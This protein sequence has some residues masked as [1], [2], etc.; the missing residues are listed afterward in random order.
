MHAK[1]GHPQRSLETRRDQNII[2]LSLDDSPLL[3]RMVLFYS[4]LD[5]S[6]PFLPFEDS[7]TLRALWKCSKEPTASWWCQDLYLVWLM[8]L[9]YF[10]WHSFIVVLTS[11]DAQTFLALWIFS[12]KPTASWWCQD[13]YLV[14]QMVLFYFWWYSFIVVLT[15]HGLKWPLRMPKLCVHFGNLLR[16]LPT[17]GWWCQDY[18]H[19]IWFW[20]DSWMSVNFERSFWCHRFD[21][22]PTKCF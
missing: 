20:V 6:W 21:Q 8:V 13:L 15:S 11:E 16:N 4:C 18:V 12:K 22:K 17:V 1:F 10:W 9:F 3:L 14:Y 2:T 5:L 7:Q 19:L